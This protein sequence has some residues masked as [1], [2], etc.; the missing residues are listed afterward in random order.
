MKTVRFIPA[1]I[2]QLK[3]RI[4]TSKELFYELDLRIKK[5][6]IHIKKAVFVKQPKTYYLQIFNYKDITC[7]TEQ[8]K[9]QAKNKI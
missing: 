5:K 1:T 4:Y 9:N 2:M 3:R 8:L 6:Y 7:R